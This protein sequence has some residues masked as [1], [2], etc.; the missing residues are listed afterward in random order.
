MRGPG[1]SDSWETVAPGGNFRLKAEQQAHMQSLQ[2]LSSTRVEVLM[3][4]HRL[5]R[6]ILEEDEDA[7]TL[8]RNI[9][10]LG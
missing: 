10:Q 9:I 1:R 3:E 2:D 5:D 4:M 8:Q 6:D 7:H